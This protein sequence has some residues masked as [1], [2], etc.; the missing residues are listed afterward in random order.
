MDKSNDYGSDSLSRR[1]EGGSLH[2]QDIA[3]SHLIPVAFSTL[4]LTL[5]QT[6]HR[7]EN[8][9][10]HLMARIVSPLL[11]RELAKRAVDIRDITG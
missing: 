9:V 5:A 7:S 1:F 2:S 10:F 4:N 6:P 3:L 8:S 11:E